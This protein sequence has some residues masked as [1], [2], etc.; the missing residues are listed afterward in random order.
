MKHSDLNITVKADVTNPGQFFAC[1]GLLELAD[2]L[3]PGAEGWFA[4]GQFHVTCEGTLKE[5]VTTLAQAELKQLDPE[6]PTSSRLE[7]GNPFRDLRLDWW[8]DERAGGKEL[9][10]W[11]G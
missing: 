7:V 1:C 2:R 3:W 8:H 11:A 10:V 4:D 6:D 9:K 5:L